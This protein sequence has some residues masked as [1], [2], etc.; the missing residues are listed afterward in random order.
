M[1]W[2]GSIPIRVALG[3][4]EYLLRETL[5]VSP[6]EFESNLAGKIQD[7]DFPGDVQHLMKDGGLYDPLKAVEL[8]IHLS[9]HRGE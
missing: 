8:A 1:A 5:R 4:A 6:S 7:P 2:T 3:F 9:E